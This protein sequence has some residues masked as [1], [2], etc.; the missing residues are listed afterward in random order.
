MR[1]SGAVF[2]DIRESFGAWP[3]HTAIIW[4][5]PMDTYQTPDTNIVVIELAG[6]GN[7]MAVTLFS[8][9]LAVEGTRELPLMD[10]NVYHQPGIKYGDF[11]AEVA[12]HTPV[13]R[14]NLKVDEMNRLLKTILQKLN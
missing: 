1:D 9:L 3:M 6:V 5:S 7:N 14:G 11:R 12:I 4:R 13:D 2:Q 8:D 10:M